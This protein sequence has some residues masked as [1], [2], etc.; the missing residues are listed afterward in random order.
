MRRD[1]VVRRLRQHQAEI[2]RLGVRSL[3]LF[4]SAARDDARPDS[5]ID[6]YFDYDD[7]RFSLIELARLQDRLRELLGAPIDLMTRGS[8][9]PRLRS[10][11]Q[12]SSLQ[13]F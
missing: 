13:V 2:R 11:I 6:P 10:D 8:L 12:Q 5:D 3:Y 7:P 1:D 4:G 9:H